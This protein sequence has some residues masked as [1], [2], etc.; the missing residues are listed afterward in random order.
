MNIQECAEELGLVTS[1]DSIQPGDTYLAERNTGPHLLTC[2]HIVNNDL[3]EPS[4]VVPTEIAYCYDVWE[5]VK[6]IDSIEEGEAR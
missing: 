2:D 6:V 1:S 3:G 5:C 4:Y